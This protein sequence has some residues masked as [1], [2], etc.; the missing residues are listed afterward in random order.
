M[1]W[2]LNDSPPNFQQE[3]AK[4]QRYYNK[5]CIFAVGYSL[6]SGAAIQVFIPTPVTFRDNLLI[7]NQINNIVIRQGGKDLTTSAK[8]TSIGAVRENGLII[9]IAPPSGI[10]LTGREIYAVYP[11]DSTTTLNVS[12]NM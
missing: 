9:N 4:C 7:E 2:V 8:V 6:A 10:T 11:L 1:A 3:L 12:C 5:L